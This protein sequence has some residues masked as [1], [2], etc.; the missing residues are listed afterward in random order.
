MASDKKARV[1]RCAERERVLGRGTSGARVGV[2]R[3]DRGSYATWNM[4]RWEL[5]FTRPYHDQ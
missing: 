1:G 5:D 3:T 4:A 2:S